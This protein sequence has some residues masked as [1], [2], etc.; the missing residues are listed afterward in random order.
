[1]LF[2][3]PIDLAAYLGRTNHGEGSQTL[4]GASETATKTAETG[5]TVLQETK[6]SPLNSEQSNDP[7][8]IKIRII[9]YITLIQNR[10]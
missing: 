3:V 8:R 1:M 9:S 4:R 2:L 10:Q 6:K 7:I 5:R